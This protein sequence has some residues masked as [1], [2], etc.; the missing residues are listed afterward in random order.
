[1]DWGNV[2]WDTVG[3]QLIEPQYSLL[4]SACLLYYDYLLTFPSEIHLIWQSRWSKA[5]GFYLAIRY[6]ALLVITLGL[7]HVFFPSTHSDAG[8]T[9]LSCRAVLDTVLV[10]NAIHFAIISAFV[11]LRISAIWSRNRYLGVSLF[12]LGLVNPSVVTPMLAFGFQAV[13][14]PRPLVAC[15][16][17]L[18]DDS[19]SLGVLLLRYFPIITSAIGIVYEGLCLLLTVIKTFSLYRE[20]RAMGMST[21]LTSLLLRDGSL[22][23]GVLTL[24]AV[25]NIVSASIPPGSLPTD[26]Q[27]FI[28]HVIA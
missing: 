2:D 27:T 4:S 8:M 18:P 17:Y 19:N 12:L 22:Y 25:L 9:P 26:L 13:P 23:F 20:Q 6:G 10:V 7:F 21:K 1:M 24:L 3:L 16:S 28:P 11:A 15:V 5:A 14:A